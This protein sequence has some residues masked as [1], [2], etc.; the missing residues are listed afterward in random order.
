VSKY[1][2]FIYGA[3][4][5]VHN[6]S[7]SPSNQDVSSDRLHCLTDSPS[8]MSMFCFLLYIWMILMESYQLK[9][10]QNASC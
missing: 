9:A 7:W 2:S 6:A 10:V 5:T 1:A 3:V 8:V 4:E